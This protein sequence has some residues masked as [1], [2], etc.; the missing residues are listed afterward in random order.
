MKSRSTEK[1]MTLL[2]V[3]IYVALLSFLISGFLNFAVGVHLSA[4]ELDHEIEDA[5]NK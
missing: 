1:G 5:Q 3:I 4:I 2:E